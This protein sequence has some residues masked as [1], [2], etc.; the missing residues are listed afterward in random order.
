MSAGMKTGSLLSGAEEPVVRFESV[1]MRYGLGSEVLSDVSFEIAPHSFQ[2][3]TGPSGAGK[4][5]LLRLILLSV[6]PTRGLVSIFGKE[7]SGISND[8]LTGLRRRMGVVFQDFRL[9]DHLTTYENVALPLRVQ[10]R[11]EASYRAEVV[12]LLRWVGL[13]ERMHVLPPLLSGGEKQ[14]AAI[15]RALIARPELL[16]A[17][18]PT[19]NVDPSLARRLLRLF[20][21]LNRLG[22]SV[23]IATHDYSLMDLV[24]ARRMVLAEGRLRV[25]GP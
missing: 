10:E 6:R 11:S 25:E 8:A 1:G 15:A 16:L 14:R 7:V 17:D 5:T 12:E 19:G 23:V 21:E 13:G 20:M 2:F 3:L 24:E 22:T 4:T 9:L 18:E